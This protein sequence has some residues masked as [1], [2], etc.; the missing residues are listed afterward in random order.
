LLWS[1]GVS[2][3]KTGITVAA[4][5]CLA[6]CLNREG[7]DLVIVLLCCKSLEARWV[8]TNKLANWSIAR[9]KKIKKFQNQ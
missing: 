5:P 6:T 9:L 8:E 1:K 4:G 2:G 7:L 3:I